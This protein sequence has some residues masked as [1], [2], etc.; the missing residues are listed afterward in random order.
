M[1]STGFLCFNEAGANPPR[2]GST[3]AGGLA[4]AGACFNEAGANPPRKGIV[5]EGIRVCGGC[6]ASM[7]PGR[8]RPGK[9]VSFWDDATATAAALQ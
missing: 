6:G 2:K 3:V 4:D 7:R 8:I 5:G 9:S 1:K